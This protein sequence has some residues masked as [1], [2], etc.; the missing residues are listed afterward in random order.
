[1][2]SQIAPYITLILLIHNQMFKSNF[3]IL[4][5]NLFLL[6]AKVETGK[7]DIDGN[8]FQSLLMLIVMFSVKGT[9]LLYMF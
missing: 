6:N 2:H 5:V 4:L 7:R 1:M 3:E 8:T 9:S